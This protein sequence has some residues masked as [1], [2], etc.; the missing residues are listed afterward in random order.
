[1]NELYNIKQ[2]GKLSINNAH[3]KENTAQELFLNIVI[4]LTCIPFLILAIVSPMVSRANAMK[5]K[6]MTPADAI[7]AGTFMLL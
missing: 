6:M 5:I 1:M 4:E 7:I 3:Y 2:Y